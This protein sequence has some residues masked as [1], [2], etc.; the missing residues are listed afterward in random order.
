[1]NNET[2]RKRFAIAWNRLYLYPAPEPL[3]RTRSF[4]IAMGA[5]SLLVIAFCVLFI[6]FITGQ[7]DAFMT[8]GEDLGIMDQAIWSIWHGQWFHQTI[9]SHTT[10]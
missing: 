1:M 9:C 3:P 5:V 10:F 4:W 6:A 8:H 2:W 7:Q